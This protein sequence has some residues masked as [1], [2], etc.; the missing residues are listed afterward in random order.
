MH[1]LHHFLKRNLPVNNRVHF[2]SFLW[3]A[4]LS[5]VRPISSVTGVFGRLGEQLSDSQQCQKKSCL[6]HS[7]AVSLAQ[8]RNQSLMC[9]VWTT[10]PS[11]S[12]GCVLFSG[13]T[14]LL[15]GHTQTGSRQEYSSIFTVW[16]AAILAFLQLRK[17]GLDGWCFSQRNFMNSW[18][19]DIANYWPDP[20]QLRCSC[21][22]I[23]MGQHVLSQEPV[24]EHDRD[25]VP[26]KIH[27]PAVLQLRFLL[28]PQLSTD[29]CSFLG[30]IT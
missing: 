4:D 8:T 6:K 1:F 26:L 7:Q 5:P 22:V 25:Y 29:W 10:W 27:F 16:C 11:G 3:V 15:H 24:E 23:I 17:V 14:R 2:L 12:T 21:F 30:G 18:L 13:P 9:S 19:Q 20:D 28:V